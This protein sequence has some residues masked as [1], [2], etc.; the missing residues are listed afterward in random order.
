MKRSAIIFSLIL[1]CL[2]ATGEAFGSERLR[3]QH[4]RDL[5]SRVSDEAAP[6]LY[7]FGPDATVTVLSTRNRAR[8]PAQSIRSIIPKRRRSSYSKQPKEARASTRA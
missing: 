7:R 1:I 4:R 3:V 6:L 5:E 8:S 2:A